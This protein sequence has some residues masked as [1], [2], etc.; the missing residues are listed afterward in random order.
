M[1]Y[2]HNLLML[3]SSDESESEVEDTDT[4]K[5]STSSTAAVSASPADNSNTLSDTTT[6]Q[7]PGSSRQQE[8]TP[9]VDRT[10][11]AAEQS[12]QPDDHNRLQ[13]I[14]D[15][16][17]VEPNTKSVIKKNASKGMI[18]PSPKINRL[19]SRSLMELLTA[20]PDTPNMDDIRV[21]NFYT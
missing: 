2:L 19:E 13:S 5:S 9:V 3:L 7:S 10:S 1:P 4:T 14:H 12:V 17:Q 16:I 6:T 11:E 21:S 20:K 15:S 18:D 8:G